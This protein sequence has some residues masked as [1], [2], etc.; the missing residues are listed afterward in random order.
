MILFFN[1]TRVATKNPK[2]NTKISDFL[3]S[4]SKSQTQTQKSQTQTRFSKKK[5]KKKRKGTQTLT[6]P[7]VPNSNEPKQE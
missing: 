4:L 7:K 2:T 1:R 6:I 5:K 3:F